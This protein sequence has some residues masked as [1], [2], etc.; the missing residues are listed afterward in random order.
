ML[1]KAIRT[2]IT[3]VGTFL[4]GAVGLFMWA[5]S[6]NYPEEEYLRL[7]ETTQQGNMTNDSI[8]SIMTYN[9]GYLSGMT[10]NQPVFS[11]PELFE[12]NL[13][14]VK[15][16]LTNINPDI[17]CLQEIDYNSCR[18]YHVN[19]QEE[20]QKLGYGYAYQAVNWDVNYLPFPGSPVDLSNHYAEVYS[21][22]SI[23]SRYPISDP[24]RIALKR[25]NNM[26]FYR[27]AFYL[28]RLAQVCFVNLDGKK[29]AIINVHLEAFDQ[30]TRKEQTRQ[31]MELYNQYQDRMPVLLVGDFNSDPS[32]GGATI[33]DILNIPGIASAGIDG[34]KTYP[35]VNPRTRLDYIFYNKNYIEIKDAEVV[36]SMED[37]SDHLPLLMTFTF[38]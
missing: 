20:I 5:T 14:R 24:E 30:A 22:Q 23:I 13:T 31:L 38:K 33:S 11:T 8:Y 16:N 3:I 25:V 9:I 28:D 29:V 19:Q 10:N 34:D 12:N 15:N 2:F 21:G 35:S 36:T 37:A 1:K 17:I 4:L 18:S 27:D 32:S 26:P 6:S 7:I